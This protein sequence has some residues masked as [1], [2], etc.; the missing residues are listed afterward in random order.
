MLLNINRGKY[1]TKYFNA[2]LK[3]MKLSKIVRSML[4]IQEKIAMGMI[5]LFKILLLKI[6][7]IHIIA[8]D[9]KTE[10]IIQQK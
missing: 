5:I 4:A 3:L 1:K 2:K 8:N 7:T 10:L 9:P 6:N